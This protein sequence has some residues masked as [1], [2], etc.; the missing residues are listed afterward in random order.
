MSFIK[1]L[2]NKFHD[3]VHFIADSASDFFSVLIHNLS[4][5]AGKLLIHAAT[6]AV[7]DAEATGGTGQEKFQAAFQ[8]IVDSL[9]TEGLPII[10]ND[11]HAA[12]VA[13]VANMNAEK[14]NA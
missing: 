6:K 2:Q 9:T 7:A 10:V 8:S 14:T 12:I 3:L 13:A 11:V 5:D 1:D 4:T